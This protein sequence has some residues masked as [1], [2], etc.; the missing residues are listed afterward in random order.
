[1]AVLAI[2]KDQPFLSYG[3]FFFTI[4]WPFQEQQI[5]QAF[6][7]TLNIIGDETKNVL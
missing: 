3:K 5:A 6:L 7:K 2:F 1:M 4:H